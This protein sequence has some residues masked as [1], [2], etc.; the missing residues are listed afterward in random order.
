MCKT[1][2]KIVL[3][4]LTNSDAS[5]RVGKLLS[6]AYFE[7]DITSDQLDIQHVEVDSVEVT[8]SR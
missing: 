1:H 7:P 8:D 3:N 6:E 2:W 5:F 4:V